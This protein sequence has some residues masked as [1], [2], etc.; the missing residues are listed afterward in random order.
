MEAAPL[1]LAA[2]GLSAAGSLFGGSMDSQGDQV[3]AQNA[4]NAAE[5]GKIKASQTDADMRRK[6]TTQLANISAVRAGL[7]LNPNSPTG[8]AIGSNVQAIGDLNRGYAIDNINQQVN[9]DQQAASFYTSSASNAL[10]GGM[11]GAAGSIFKGLGGSSG[12]GPFQ[13]P[14]FGMGNPLYR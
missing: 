2:T 14:S 9:M 12:G 3:E 8:Q 1:A 10:L 7:G 13:M 4:V 11:F 6:L 5:M